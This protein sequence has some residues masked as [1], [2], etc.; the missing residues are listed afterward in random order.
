MLPFSFSLLVE[1]S[2]I[3]GLLSKSQK[4]EKKKTEWLTPDKHYSFDPNL[5]LEWV[6]LVVQPFEPLDF[7][8]A[9]CVFL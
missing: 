2:D 4:V 9:L 5:K 7:G 6:M 3:D 1:P 8:T